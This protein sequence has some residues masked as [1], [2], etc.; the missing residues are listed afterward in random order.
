MANTLQEAI[1]GQDGMVD[2]TRIEFEVLGGGR[3]RWNLFGPDRRLFSAVASPVDHVSMMHSTRII[4]DAMAGIPP[5]FGSPTP[6][7]DGLDNG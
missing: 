6:F 3:C 1:C 7:N 5:I 4:L 2:V